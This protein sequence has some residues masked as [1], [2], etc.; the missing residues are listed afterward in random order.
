MLNTLY[1]I[2]SRAKSYSRHSSQYR[3]TTSKTCRGPALLKTD[4]FHI[5]ARATRTPAVPVFFWNSSMSARDLISPLPPFARTGILRDLATSAIQGDRH[6]SLLSDYLL[7]YF[8]LI[9]SCYLKNH[10]IRLIFIKKY[11]I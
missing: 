2:T 6:G 8:L 3:L 1:F 4:G 9:A 11:L 7:F 5:A 10:L